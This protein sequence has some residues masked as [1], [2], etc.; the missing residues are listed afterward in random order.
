MAPC[1]RHVVLVAVLAAFAPPVLAQPLPLPPTSDPVSFVDHLY[2]D[3]LEHEGPTGGPVIA[4]G[5][6]DG[7]DL[8]DIVVVTPSL[9]RLIRQTAPGVFAPDEP[10]AF[11]GGER[12]RA[13]ALTDLDDDGDLDLVYAS[14]SGPTLVFLNDGSGAFTQV[15]PPVELP[16]PVAVV[17]LDGDGR[18]DFVAAT[19]NGD[20]RIAFREGPL[21]FTIQSSGG[22]V[23]IE[24]VAVGLINGDSRMDFACGPYYWV[25]AFPR[26]FVR[27]ELPNARI[28]AIVDLD[29]DGDGDLVSTEFSFNQSASRWTVYRN[30]FLEFTPMATESWPTPAGS[31]AV[32]ADVDNDG[33]TDLLLVYDLKHWWP[34][35]PSIISFASYTPGTVV[36]MRSTGDGA[37]AEYQNFSTG[38]ALTNDLAL[39][40]FTAG[41]RGIDVV[42]VNQGYRVMNLNPKGI[43]DIGRTIAIA[44]LDS[45]G[46]YRSPDRA[47]SELIS[48]GPQSVIFAD[49]SG[50]DVPDQVVYTQAGTRLNVRLGIEGGRFRALPVESASTRTSGIG[51]DDFVGDGVLRVLARWTPSES[52]TVG[53]IA[54]NPMGWVVPGIR[55]VL[56]YIDYAPGTP[57]A[58]FNGDGGFDLVSFPY[59]SGLPSTTTVTTSVRTAI[60]AF[61]PYQELI[62]SGRV[63]AAFPIEFTGDAMSDLLLVKLDRNA[64][65]A[66]P[67]LRVPAVLELWANTGTGFEPAGN[68]AVFSEPDVPFVVAHVGDLNND[69]TTDIVALVNDFIPYHLPSTIHIYLQQQGVF[70][71][72]PPIQFPDLTMIRLAL[73][74]INKDGFLDIGAIVAD[75]GPEPYESRIHRRPLF[76]FNNGA[77]EFTTAQHG[78]YSPGVMLNLG[79]TDVDGDGFVD[80]NTVNAYIPTVQLNRNLTPAPPPIPGDANGHGLVNGADLSVLLSMFG[81]KTTPGNGADF[82]NDGVV[83]GA[84]L[85]ILLANF[86]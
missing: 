77:G 85:S 39:G 55:A 19:F 82:N 81:Q 4:V 83:N 70:V 64:E 57:R 10:V 49:I 65:G 38:G 50:D 74:D 47:V 69:G 58:D 63:D 53:I 48:N 73:A 31:R 35:S 21:Q 22:P 9:L 52:Y 76:L 86:S 34:N 23:S 8:D 51:Y 15:T 24:P 3:E 42:T 5:D 12:T 18:D 67:P 37:F 44:E 14:Y 36:V 68:V 7:D 17:D 20:Y 1:T 32:P 54:G 60:D 79:F 75:S 43:F 71:A 41:S 61:E 72:Q 78:P 66:A 13:V 30:D 11:P 33:L 27:R 56:Q 80:L 84:D 6:I 29:G 25:Q 62:V 16:A 2:V 46:L 26:Q 45:S 40:R 59:P 28:T